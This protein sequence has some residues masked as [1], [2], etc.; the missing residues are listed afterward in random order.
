MD[1]GQF[2]VPIRG[3]DALHP[4]G[5]Y[6]APAKVFHWI[7]APLLPFALLTGFVIDHIKD[8]HQMPFYALH[9]STGLIILTVAV[10]RLCWRLMSPPPDLPG[11]VS[12]GTR[13]AAA[14]VHHALYACLIIQPILGFVTTNAFGFPLQGETAFLGFIDFP[15]F[16]ETNETLAN[17]TMTAHKAVA[18]LLLVL[19]PLHVAGAIHHHAIRRDGTLLRML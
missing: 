13:R 14:A 4:D 3:Q 5:Q 12:P 8:D 10:L 17:A 15:K 16:M 18:V 7:T 11:H 9:E 19:I 2:A 6:S 1:Q